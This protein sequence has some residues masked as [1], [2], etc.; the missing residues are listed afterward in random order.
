MRDRRKRAG[1]SWRWALRVGFACAMTAVALGIPVVHAPGGKVPAA[2]TGG[3]TSSAVEG[4]LALQPSQIAQPRY[5]ITRYAASAPRQGSEMGRLKMRRLG[6]D[7][8]VVSVGW[9]REAIAV[10][11]DPHTLGWFAPSAHL[12]DLAGVSLIVG[13]VSDRADYPGP[14]ARLSNARLGDRIRWQ[15]GDGHRVR[16]RVVAIGR[17]PRATG[18]PPSLFRVD[19]LHTLRLVTC[20]NRQTSPSGVHYADNLVVSAVAE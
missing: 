1:H 8:R 6:I 7:V 9:D 13:H 4:V 16:F 11:D 10:P 15:R 5:L 14:L 12:N 17:Y 2:P 19:G 3:G 20:T 18:L